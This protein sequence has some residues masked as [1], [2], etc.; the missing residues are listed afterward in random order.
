[1]IIE[2]SFFIKLSVPSSSN[3]FN[4]KI[5]EIKLWRP[6]LSINPTI[7]KCPLEDDSS[8]KKKDRGAFCAKVDHQNGIQMVKWL[9]NKPVIVGSNFKNSFTFLEVGKWKK[10]KMDQQKLLFKCHQLSETTIWEWVALTWWIMLFLVT[11]LAFP[12]KSGTSV[13][14]PI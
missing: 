11:G 3:K 13:L 1:M 10:A 5:F 7:N 14:L 8:F 6:V 4:E 12:V 9:D 2:I